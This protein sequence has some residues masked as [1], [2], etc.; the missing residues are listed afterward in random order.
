MRL[1]LEG[2]WDLLWW[3]YRRLLTSNSKP[4][5]FWCVVALCMI[6]FF[7]NLMAY[8]ECRYGFVL[9]SSKLLNLV[10]TSF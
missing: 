3:V 7:L 9:S 5:K 4:I 1:D 8:V 2:D 6:F 10:Q